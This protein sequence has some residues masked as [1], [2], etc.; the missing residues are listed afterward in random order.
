M[1]LFLALLPGVLR[2]ASG[3]RMVRQYP[4]SS[5]RK[6]GPITTGVWFFAKYVGQLA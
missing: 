5:L 6:Q 4:V 1:M 3:L 2:K